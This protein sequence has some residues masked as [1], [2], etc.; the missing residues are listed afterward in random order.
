MEPISRATK[1]KPGPTGARRSRY[2]ALARRI[3]RGSHGS[4]GHRRWGRFERSVSLNNHGSG[5]AS[6]ECC[7]LFGNW[8]GPLVFWRGI[9]QFPSKALA[10]LRSVCANHRYSLSQLLCS[11]VTG[12]L[13][14]RLCP[15]IPI[16]EVGLW[17]QIRRESLAETS[18]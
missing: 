13:P 16:R 10:R 8:I 6:S 17:L 2:F 12:H 15:A 9:F 11:R 18:G 5:L 4:R 3:C 14:A 1:D 7:N